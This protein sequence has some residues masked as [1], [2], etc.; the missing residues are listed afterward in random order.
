M[1]D[2]TG[3]AVM[4]PSHNGPRGKREECPL[5]S[6]AVITDVQYAD[7][8]D[9]YSF[10][11]VPRYFR[12][13]LE[14]LREAVS[15][16]N[17][18]PTLKFGIQLGDIVDGRCPKDQSLVA[19]GRVLEAFKSFRGGPFFHVIGNHCLYNLPR[20]TL[21]QLLNITP[22]AGGSSYYDFCPSESFRFVMLDGYDISAIGWPNDHPHTQLGN[23]ILNER[24][25]NEDKNSPLGM[26]GTLKR[27]VKFNGGIGEDQIVWLKSKLQEASRLGQKVVICCHL[28]IHPDCAHSD[29]LLWNFDKVLEVLH[30]YSC[31]VAC[32]SGHVHTGCHV[33]DSHGIHHRVLEAVLECPPGTNAFGHVDVYSDRLALVG[34]SNMKSTEMHFL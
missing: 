1:G 8:P 11:G 10:L 14:A 34:S 22:S 28:P 26:H 33:V 9:G 20:E 2:I 7:V 17:C 3:V 21:Y 5:F 32:L 23:S 19:A 6:F 25:P 18:N 31:V 29:A 4:H 12:H 15:C 30:S 13:S 24:N 27:F 16:W